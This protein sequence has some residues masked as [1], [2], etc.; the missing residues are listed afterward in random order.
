LAAPQDH[1]A[2]PGPKARQP[3]TQ[4]GTATPSA[5]ETPSE[6]AMHSA[7]ATQNATAEL[8]PDHAQ[9]ESTKR[10]TMMEDRLASGTS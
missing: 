6:T 10:L 4:V 7:I 3:R 9:R 8:T 5:I 1:K 2:N